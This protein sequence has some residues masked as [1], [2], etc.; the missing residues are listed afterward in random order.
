MFLQREGIKE[1]EI[2][3]FLN[4]VKGYFTY[5]VK[6]QSDDMNTIRNFNSTAKM[7][8]FDRNIIGMNF[9]ETKKKKK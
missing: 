2:N 5:M 7:G 3:T 8:H 1:V 6:L 4:V 9:K